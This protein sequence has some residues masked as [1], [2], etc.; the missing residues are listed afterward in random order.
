MPGGEAPHREVEFRYKGGWFSAIVL[1][2]R[3]GT[4]LIV[5]ETDGSI[6][7]VKESLTRR[8][9]PDDPAAAALVVAFA[10]APPPKLG[11]EKTAAVTAPKKRPAV[12]TPPA[13]L[14][15]NSSGAERESDVIATPL[16]SSSVVPAVSSPAPVLAQAAASSS[17]VASPAVSKPYQ[18]ARNKSMDGNSETLSP[19]HRRK[20][21]QQNTITGNESVVKSVVKELVLFPS[22]PGCR[23]DLDDLTP[24]NTQANVRAIRLGVFGDCGVGKSALVRAIAGEEF[25]EMIPPTVFE[26]VKHSVVTGSTKKEYLVELWD[27]SGSDRYAKK[28]PVIYPNV[29]AFVVCFDINDHYSFINC[30]K[31]W[32]PEVASAC[33]GL[34]VILVATKSDRGAAKV[35]QS[36]IDNALRNCAAAA[37]ARPLL[38]VETSAKNCK[39]IDDLFVKAVYCV[40]FDGSKVEQRKG[41]GL[42]AAHKLAQLEEM[43]RAQKVPAIPAKPTT[44]ATGGGGSKIGKTQSSS[45]LSRSSGNMSPLGRP[46]SPV[47]VAS[48]PPPL[49]EFDRQFAAM[50]V[51]APT[52]FRHLR[53]AADI[54]KEFDAEYAGK[55]KRPAAIPI[56][57]AQ[58]TLRTNAVSPVISPKSSSVPLAPVT[59]PGV[60]SPR[61]LQL[62]GVVVSAITPRGDNSSN[63]ISA[64]SPAAV[65]MWTDSAP[66]YAPVNG[67]V[68]CVVQTDFEAE[69]EGDLS[70]AKGEILALNEQQDFAEEYWYGAKVDGTVGYCPQNCVDWIEQPE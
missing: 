25:Q 55:Q 20:E 11:P 59:A 1:S 63:S 64:S 47:V 9:M 61:E 62:M 37:C 60:L 12:P 43:R 10:I 24:D 41:P 42:Q 44:V 26:T 66:K 3:D 54:L 15:S 46:S 5:A 52:G 56:A 7:M 4:L 34:P 45:D 18:H 28:R 19:N 14:R 13:R 21:K 50:P 27:V 32:L 48:P 53:S 68:F 35:T 29:N 39:F 23:F 16:A 70:G 51:S 69:K 17:P 36:E 65:L 8:A 57:Q 33:A 30:V 67:T 38:Y 31:T 2:Q 49:S 58:A 6:H 40:L 22:D